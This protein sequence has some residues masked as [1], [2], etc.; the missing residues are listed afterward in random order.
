MRVAMVTG[1][2][3]GIG[4]ATTR[5]FAKHGYAVV[6]GGRRRDRLDELVAGGGEV[7][8]VPGDVTDPRTVPAMFDAAH[9]RWGRVPDIAVLCAGLGLPGTVLTSDPT[10][11]AELAETNYLSVLRQLR[12]CADRM[13]GDEGTGGTTVSDIV[14][15]GST[16]GRQVSSANPVY[17][18]TKFAVH[19]LVDALRQEVCRRGVRVSLIE[20]GFVRTGFQGTAGYDPVWFDEVDR[21]NGPLLTADDVAAAI[22]FVVAQPPHVHVD[23]LRIRPTRQKT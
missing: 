11:W 2:T 5:L 17:G 16:V 20:P 14:V 4:E 6:A 21:D 22:A 18:A 19:S 23:D 13:T 9:G 7:L 1:A 15:V 10:L 3:S 12:D 8:A